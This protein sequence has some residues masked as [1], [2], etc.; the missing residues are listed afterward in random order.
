MVAL[1]LKECLILQARLLSVNN[2]RD[3]GL[4]DD[5]RNC[6]W[7]VA[8]NLTP[9]LTKRNITA[10]DVEHILDRVKEAIVSRCSVSF[11]LSRICSTSPAVMFR[12]VRRGVKLE[13]TIQAQLRAYSR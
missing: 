11:T 10:G 3:D 6:A 7:I 2:H 13:A 4:S 5:R 1:M 12:L 9:R 8:S